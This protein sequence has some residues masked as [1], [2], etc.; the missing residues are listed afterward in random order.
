MSD[1]KL[2]IKKPLIKVNPQTKAQYG[3]VDSYVSTIENDRKAYCSLCLIESP[4]DP[5]LPIFKELKEADADVYYCG[6]CG[7]G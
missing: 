2:E 4:S 6:C 3:N 1:E 7:W 5:R